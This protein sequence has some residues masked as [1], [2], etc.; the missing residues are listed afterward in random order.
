MKIGP[1]LVLWIS[2]MA[3]CGTEKSLL[4]NAKFDKGLREKIESLPADTTV[5]LLVEGTCDTVINGLMRQDLI[6]AGADV[7]TMK[8]NTFTALVSSGDLSDIAY[9]EFVS[10][11]KL[12]KKK[13]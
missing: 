9:L 13:K 7:Q 8:G 4:E 2:L 6:D 10:R 12:L 11:L 5:S 3:G 1:L